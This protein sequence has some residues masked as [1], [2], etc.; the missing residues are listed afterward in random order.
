MA[1]DTLL[2]ISSFPIQIERISPREEGAS[3]AI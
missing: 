1:E 2:L 3:R